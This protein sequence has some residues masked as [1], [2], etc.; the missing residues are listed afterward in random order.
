VNRRKPGTGSQSLLFPL[1]ER[2]P[3]LADIRF[4]QSEHPVWTE[5]K[6]KLIEQYLY[7]FVLLTK[8]GTYIDGFAGPQRPD[9]PEMWSAKLVLESKPQWLRN[10]FLFDKSRQQVRRLCGLRKAQGTV[11]GRTIRI[12][13]GDFNS[14]VCQLLSRNQISQKEATFCLLDQRT[15]QCDWN[16]LVRVAQYKGEDKPKIEL[17]YFLAVKWLMRAL[18]AVQHEAVLRQW[19]GR[20]DWGTLKALKPN[21]IRDKFVER[22]KSELGYKSVL[23][24]PIYK[25]EGSELIVYYMI[26]A[27]DHADGPKLMA[28]AYNAAV[29]PR[30]EQMF[31]EW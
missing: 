8:H 10:I 30:G 3:E 28:R 1:P 11:S 20:D 6:A 9:K 16:T 26:H 7:L 13:H 12:F 24:W 21:Q 18:K 14:R 19:W 31:F 15:F 4:E 22:F 25:Q 23:A 17:F 5:S 27:T 2:T 29:W